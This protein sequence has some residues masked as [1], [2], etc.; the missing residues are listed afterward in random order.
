M[1]YSF[2]M[3]V[4]FMRAASTFCFSVELHDFV[5]ILFSKELC[6][7]SSEILEGFNY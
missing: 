3:C 7:L 1:Y 2:L 5:K 6:A 4:S